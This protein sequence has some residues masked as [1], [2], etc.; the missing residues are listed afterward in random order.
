[1]LVN[2]WTNGA[3][4]V[5]LALGIRPG[6]EVIVP[7][8]TFIATSNMVELLGARPVFADVDP[9][10]LLLDPAAVAAALTPRTRAIIPVHLYGLMCDVR[11]FQEVLRGRPDVAI[12]E[13]CAHCFE[14]ARDGCLPGKYS[15]AAIFSFYATKNVTCGEGGAVITNDSELAGRVRQTRLH[16]MSQGA[17]DRFRRGQYLHWDMA[18]LGVK[19]NLPDL[20]AALLG[21]QIATIRE[22]L[23]QRQ[24]IA[25]RYREAFAGTPI[26]RQKIPPVCSSAEH[27]F[28]IAVP[29]AVR[30]EAIAALNRREIGVAVNYRSVPTLTYYREKYSYTPESFP[31]SYAWGAGT[32][33]LPLYPTL[34]KDQQEWVIS[35]VLEEIVPLCASAGKSAGS[36]L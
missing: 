3:L 11:G 28:P 21:P 27:A 34:E 29:A 15:T 18:L 30:D 23:P 4:A 1:M 31:V 19:A 36:T 17:V 10:T 24:V 13:D 8:M 22:R 2:S 16:G 20:L 12:I 9:D 35:S 26:R 6:D 32:L 5:L 14:G 25:N 33:T 7:A